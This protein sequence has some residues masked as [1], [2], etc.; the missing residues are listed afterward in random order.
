MARLF[1]LSRVRSQSVDSVRQ[2]GEDV[3][4]QGFSGRQRGDRIPGAVLVGAD[5]AVLSVSTILCN[6]EISRAVS[7]R[8]SLL[9]VSAAA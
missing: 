5:I 4:E 3:V 2:A 7:V 6:H 1:E 8:L 9:L